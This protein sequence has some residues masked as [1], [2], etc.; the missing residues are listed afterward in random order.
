MKDY[1]EN[2]RNLVQ[3]MKVKLN[4]EFTPGDGNDS[5]VKQF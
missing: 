4:F 1:H 2:S 3:F 5:L